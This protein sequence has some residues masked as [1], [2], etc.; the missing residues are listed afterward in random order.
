MIVLLVASFAA[1]EAPLW[2]TE[3][4]ITS[5]SAL[6]AKAQARD[7][8]GYEAV[9]TSLARARKAVGDLELG[10]ALLAEDAARTA[11]AGR[12]DRSLS[13]QFLRVQKHV[14]LLGTDYSRVFGA[15]VERA[16]PSVAPGQTVIQC[17]QISQV[18]A[19]LGKGP[20]CPGTDISGKVA[21]AIDADPALQSQI[22]S[23]L[24]VD[25]PT[26]AVEGEVQAPVALTGTERSVS[27]AVL[28]RALRPDE[29]RQL[30]D[31]RAVALEQLSD[32]LNGDDRAAKRAAVA[33][34]EAVAARWRAGVA[35]L[36]K[37]LWPDVKK[38]L[39]KAA[40]KG[41]P[42]GVALCANPES[43]RGCGLPDATDAVVELLTE[44]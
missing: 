8:V 1:A 2:W 19:M 37:K 33:E 6:F 12:L 28:A 11:Y 30:D 16:L 20:R 23:I 41:G 26:I 21:A 13:G 9:Q 40:R 24:S 32:A 35:A 15:A 22:G 18:E 36:G 31:D 25:W 4:G 27:A 7:A 5:A 17:T 14:D 42:A 34:G 38:K 10:T 43:L 44:S 39:E 3:G 29:L